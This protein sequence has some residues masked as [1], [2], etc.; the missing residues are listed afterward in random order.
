[1]KRIRTSLVTLA[2][3]CSL[4]AWLRALGDPPELL[5]CSPPM[6]REVFTLT[7]D[8]VSV[9]GALPADR[10]AYEGFATRLVADDSTTVRFDWDGPGGER[11]E[12][13]YSVAR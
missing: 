2:V 5:A 10:S 13:F 11:F 6:P 9:D 8:S 1:M 7:L 3:V 4:A 12:E